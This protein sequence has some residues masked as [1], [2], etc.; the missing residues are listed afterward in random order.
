MTQAC[1]HAPRKPRPRAQRNPST[2]CA[3]A[4]RSSQ[5]RIR[6]PTGS[7]HVRRRRGDPVPLAR[8]AL[9]GQ[10]RTKPL[11]LRSPTTP[12]GSA[13]LFRTPSRAHVGPRWAALMTA[14]RCSARSGAPLPARGSSGPS[15]GG[16]RGG[17]PC[18]SH[19]RRRLRWRTAVSSG[20]RPGR[21]RGTE[22]QGGTGR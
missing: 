4:R 12:A 13:W 22:T 1:V 8:D 9:C 3:H 21:P 7:P 15:R 16:C 2:S 11:P 14:P 6:S 18:G 5:R 19:R 20:R 10:G 17:A